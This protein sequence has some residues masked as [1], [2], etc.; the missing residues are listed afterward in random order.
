MKQFRSRSPNL[1]CVFKEK[2]KY[3]ENTA[4]SNR[5]KKKKSI[6]LYLAWID[7]SMHIFIPKSSF[8]Y[9]KL[10]VYSLVFSDR[11][12]E[13]GQDSFT[14][15]EKVRFL[16]MAVKLLITK[17]PSPHPQTKV[18]YPLPS[19]SWVGRKQSLLLISSL[20]SLDN[21]ELRFPNSSSFSKQEEQK[22]ESP[23][24]VMCDS[25]STLCE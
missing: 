15:S 1:K 7:K 23:Q 25:F 14:L 17:G 22:A 8:Y 16:K 20:I 5:K 10:Y 13:K 18:G 12:S 4:D 3:N 24:N 11:V 21:R 2:Q 6:S 9:P 19:C